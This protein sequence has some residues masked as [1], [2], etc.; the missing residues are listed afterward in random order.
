MSD[1]AFYGSHRAAYPR[2]LLSI[3]LGSVPRLVAA[4]DFRGSGAA[5]HA[6]L[7]LGEYEALLGSEAGLRVGEAFQI[8]FAPQLM[9]C[10]AQVPLDASWQREPLIYTA[11]FSCQPFSCSESL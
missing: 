11:G 8:S 5:E 9:L 1:I 7:H 2:C 6:L 3:V 4:T 10:D